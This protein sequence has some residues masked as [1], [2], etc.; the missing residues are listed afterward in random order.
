[1]GASA[2]FYATAPTENARRPDIVLSDPQVDGTRMNIVVLNA[3]PLYSLTEYSARLLVDNASAGVLDPLTDGGSNGLLSFSDLDA[4]GSLS[5]G[6][7]FT[8]NRGNAGDFVLFVFWHGEQVGLRGWRESVAIT[9]AQ[10]SPTPWGYIVDVAT[11]SLPRPLGE[12]SALLKLD[13]G[14]YG[15]IGTL[16]DGAHDRNLS[17]ADRDGNGTLSAGDRFGVDLSRPGTYTLVVAWRTTDVARRVWTRA[18]AS[19]APAISL[20]CFGGSYLTPPGVGIESADPLLPIGEYR[21]AL[22]QDGAVFRELRPLAD[23]AADGTFRFWDSDHAGNVSK[24]SG[25]DRFAFDCSPEEEL[26][27]RCPGT[28]A[29][30][31]QYEFRLYWNDLLAATFSFDK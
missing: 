30:G 17:F 26:M 3:T 6:D 31:H 5:T 1:M 8:V 22:L 12:Y 7:R 20:C 25:G 24:L 29:S 2:Y 18:P 13:A 14:T 9:L 16:G 23:G 10:E 28:L 4:D 15:R 21:A 27:G 11:A 19:G